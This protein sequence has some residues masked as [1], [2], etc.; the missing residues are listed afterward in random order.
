M[1]TRRF[2]TTDFRL[3]Q[4][5][6][7]ALVEDMR[8]SDPLFDGV[9]AEE[10]LEA[11][12]YFGKIRGIEMDEN[13]E[14]V[15]LKVIHCNENGKVIINEDRPEDSFNVIKIPVNQENQKE[16]GKNVWTDDLPRVEALCERIN[17]ATDAR[18]EVIM[19]M[20][21]SKRNLLKG[22][23]EMSKPA[24][25]ISAKEEEMEE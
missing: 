8:K 9:A 4:I 7:R 12:P 3:N 2:A 22:I 25:T 5:I 23:T 15:E 10:Y 17:K 19:K 24:V 6:F 14:F 11:K 1:K 16:F 20:Y 13:D 18:M 21:Q